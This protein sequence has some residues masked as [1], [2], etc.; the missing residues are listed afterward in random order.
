VEETHASTAAV[1]DQA[2]SILH[3]CYALI[4]TATNTAA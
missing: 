4:V 1:A 3:N 2:V